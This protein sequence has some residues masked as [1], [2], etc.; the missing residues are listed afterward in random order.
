VDEN[1]TI[2]TLPM[3]ADIIVCPNCGDGSRLESLPLVT[4]VWIQCRCGYGW[5]IKWAWVSRRVN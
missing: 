4:G 2:D 3:S 5:E 1:L